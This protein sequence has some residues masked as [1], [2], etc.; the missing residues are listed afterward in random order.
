LEWQA[1]EVVKSEN[2]SYRQI[3]KQLHLKRHYVKK[4]LQFEMD[5]FKYWLRMQNLMAPNK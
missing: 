5:G 1:F 4:Q 2:P 3:I